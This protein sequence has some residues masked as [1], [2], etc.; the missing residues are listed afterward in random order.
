MSSSKIEIIAKI[1]HDVNSAYC[2]SIGEKAED[3]INAPD[4]QKK[5]FNS[6]S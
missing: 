3:W 2:R 5:T 1:A 4:W 6:W